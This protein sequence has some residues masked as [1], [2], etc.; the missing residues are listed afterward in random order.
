MYLKYLE[1]QGFKSFADKTKIELNSGIAAVVGP[2]GS[3][4]S[5]I[6]EAIRWVLGE[7][8]AKTLRGHKMQDVIFNGTKT[9]K[10][11]GLAEVSIVLDNSD[12]SLDLEYLEVKITRRLYRSGEGEYLIN[13]HNVRLKDIRRLFADSGIG[14]DGYAVIGQGRI[15]EIIDSRPEERRSIIEE[16]AGV[17]KYRDRKREALRK[18]DSA[19]QNLL[20]LNDI[21]S[22]IE[23]RLGPL[24]KDAENAK[25]FLAFDE[26]KTHLSV[27]ILA[28]AMTDGRA[29]LQKAESDSAACGALCDE[30]DARLMSF[31]TR[32]A[33][34]KAARDLRNDELRGR[35]QEYNTLKLEIEKAEGNLSIL[36]TRISGCKEKAELLADGLASGGGKSAELRVA[37]AGAEKK[38]E[39]CKGQLDALR[40]QLR[41]AESRRKSESEDLL[42]AEEEMDALRAE[43]F[44]KTREC[45]Q[46][47]NEQISLEH[48]MENASRR[49]ESIAEKHASYDEEENVLDSRLREITAVIDDMDEERT[50]L[51]EK[52]REL[53][54]LWQSYDDSEKEK[55]EQLV[56]IKMKVS[57]AEAR[58]KVLEEL[59]LK[60]EGY[61][62]GVRAVL[63][64]RSRQ[65][66]N[67]IYGVIAELI[68]VDA[69][70]TP[71]VEAVLGGALQNIVTETGE[72]AAAAV[73]YLKR[74]RKGV[75]TFLPLDMLR[76][77][78]RK[79]VPSGIEKHADYCGN[80]ADM[81][82]VPRSSRPA[83]E[84]L[85]GNTLVFRSLDTAVALS[86]KHKGL[87]RYVTLDGDV[88]QPGGTVSGGSR[89]KSR[90]NFL[91]RQ[92]EI[93]ELRHLLTVSEREISAV[94]KE[95]DGIAE[96]KTRNE[97]E[98][99][100]IFVKSENIKTEIASFDS[101]ISAADARRDFLEKEREALSLEEDQLREEL[102]EAKTSYQTAAA[103]ILA[104]Q[105]EE[106]RLIAE[107]GRREEM[108]RASKSMGER[109][110]DEYTALQVSFAE[111]KALYDT[112][113]VERN[114]LASELAEEE[115]SIE[116]KKKEHESVL[117]EISDT[118]ALRA[119]AEEEVLKKNRE[120][121]GFHQGLDDGRTALDEAEAGIENAE[122]EYR[123]LNAKL[124]AEKEKLFRF[125]G[126]VE[127]IGSELERWE[128]ELRDD[129]GMELCDA[130]PYIDREQ[131]KKDKKNR[132]KILKQQ[133]EA[134]GPVNTGA[135][136]EFKEVSER[137]AFLKSQYDDISGAK[138]A[139]E[140]VVGDMD[141]IIVRRF[142]ETFEAVDKSFRETFPAFFR[143][144]YGELKL[145]D[146]ENLLETGIEII[147][148]PP[149]KRLQHLS[150]LSGGEKSL[151]GIALLFALL[152]VKPSPFYVLD[153]IDAALDDANVRRF[154]DYLTEYGIDS[155]FLIITHR[156]GS[157][158]A[159][160]RMYG[161]TMAEEGV[162]RTV[163]VQLT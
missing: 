109:S 50:R 94:N 153:E 116:D 28:E 14:S 1:L 86:R 57:R 71:A 146:E 152:K 24:E 62:P 134:L 139:L 90:N 13:G 9:R 163:S 7:S 59:A 78:E 77:S 65:G 93:D 17:V 46:K 21:M 4:K 18:I 119:E 159:A 124:S 55:K 154:S 84:Y 52:D 48:R 130:V 127:R 144:G 138:L 122:K 145:S 49:L 99:N 69:E 141:G 2:N 128:E 105:S 75:A 64:G 25:R 80:A 89:E 27:G 83:V 60:R 162:S 104:A 43:A 118:Q 33:E 61:Y 126:T 85:L 158:E 81:V 160:S 53:L 161:V 149:G 19:E 131:S 5:N 151:S 32:L 91:Q 111:A 136:D 97:K 51:A 68:Q 76:I 115:N 45:G 73:V 103:G 74:E 137:Y 36:D 20:R 35:E 16:T 112:G 113:E 147:V 135:I 123:E 100:R 101:E 72:D 22:E 66:L 102:E 15:M 8:S 70:Y 58:L 82:K 79:K 34:K 108:F 88:I 92:N 56:E 155:Q 95:I 96:D 47:K 42:R 117:K 63:E 67:G 29:R 30:M 26:E 132:I 148:Q 121:L 98:R 142:K 12:R 140:K 39:E 3:G 10:P 125:Q 40:E 38:S 120:L 114:R 157:M 44:E 156:Q 37:L 129:Y 150:L 87:F 133:I 106:K 110:Q 54:G 31:E 11:L 143:G 6:V 23:S 41:D 107:I